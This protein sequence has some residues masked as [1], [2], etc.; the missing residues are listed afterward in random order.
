[1]PRFVTTGQEVE[2]RPVGPDPIPAPSSFVSTI[3]KTPTLNIQVSAPGELLRLFQ[4]FT[5]FD[6]R[7]AL[8][9]RA[10]TAM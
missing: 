1:M 7:I 4:L 5:V 8:L 9:S 3:P 2:P 6:S 10:A